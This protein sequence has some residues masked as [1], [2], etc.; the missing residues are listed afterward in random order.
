MTCKNCGRPIGFDPVCYCG[1]DNTA[2]VLADEERQKR[3]K[4][5]Q[6]EEQR[7]EEI[8]NLLKQILAK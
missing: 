8:I 2:L 4:L 5:F 3:Q 6:R 1:R 7:H